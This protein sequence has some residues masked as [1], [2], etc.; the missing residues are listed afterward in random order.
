MFLKI[1]I[2]QN[3]AHLFQASLTVSPLLA[4]LEK[5]KNTFCENVIVEYNQITYNLLQIIV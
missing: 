1:G 2:L 5:K 4:S 3:D